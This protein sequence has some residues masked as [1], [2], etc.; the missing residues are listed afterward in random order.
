MEKSQGQLEVESR[1]RR[2]R[3]EIKAVAD[4]L[5]KD[6]E[7]EPTGNCVVHNGKLLRPAIS[8]LSRLLL[9]VDA[10]AAY[11]LDDDASPVLVRILHKSLPQARIPAPATEGEGE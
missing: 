9:K 10:C 5:S 7:A 1:H 3:A 4:A 2:L 11:T 6:C 8:S